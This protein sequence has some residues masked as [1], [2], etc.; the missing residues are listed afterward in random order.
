VVATKN[1]IG[2]TTAKAFVTLTDDV[3][4]PSDDT[5][6]QEVYTHINGLLSK[7]K[8]PE[9]IAI[10]PALPKTATGKIARAELR[11]RQE[12]DIHSITNG[13]KV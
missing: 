4:R 12:G 13:I 11:H 2:L 7:Y 5:I 3:D 9:V 6:R 10:V 8:I 1:A